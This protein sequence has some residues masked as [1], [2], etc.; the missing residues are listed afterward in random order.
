MTNEELSAIE[1]RANAATPGPWEKREVAHEASPY[2]PR[3][4]YRVEI[5]SPQYCMGR[6][7]HSRGISQ[8]VDYCD[9]TDH[10]ANAA[11][12]AHA[13]ADVPALI[14]ALREAWERN[15]NITAAAE[16]ILRCSRDADCGDHCSNSC[17]Y[18]QAREAIKP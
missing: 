16:R 14:A 1:A 5:I 3:R 10:P 12:I 15:R 7:T 17:M 11:F 8:I 2:A 6:R 13:R 9:W 18:C 4:V